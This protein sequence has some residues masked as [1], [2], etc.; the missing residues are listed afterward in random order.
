MVQIHGNLP[1]FDEFFYAKIQKKNRQIVSSRYC[2]KTSSIG[3][4]WN[5]L[6]L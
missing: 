4:F 5:F 2:T 6:A 1:S 3:V